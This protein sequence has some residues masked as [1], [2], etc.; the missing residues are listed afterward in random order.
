MTWTAGKSNL[1]RLGG[2]QTL[3]HA[4]VLNAVHPDDR[5]GVRS[6][7]YGAV[8]RSEPYFREFRVVLPSGAIR[9]ILSRGTVFHDAEGRPIRMLGVNV[10]ITDRKL[11][12]EALADSEERFRETFE[13]AEVGIAHVLPSARFSLTNAKMRALFGY[14]SD[15]MAALTVTDIIYP[16]D[17]DGAVVDRD[18]LFSGKVKSYTRQRR[19]VRKDRSVFPAEVMA[20]GVRNA[21]GAIKYI[22]LI[23]T[24]VSEAKL[25]AEEMERALRLADAANAA[26]S[27]F[28]ANVSHEIRTPLTA[29]MGFAELLNAPNVD[30]RRQRQ[31]AE[32]IERNGTVLRAL[33]DDILDLSR[34]EAGR[35]GIEIARLS[36]FDLLAEVEA[37]FQPLATARKLALA[38]VRVD[39]VPDRIYGDALRLR[40][41]LINLVGNALKFTEEGGVTLTVEQR[42]P[43]NGLVELAFV[44]TDTG[45]GIAEA[46]KG[47]LFQAFSQADPSTTRKYGGTGLGLVLTR[48]LTRMFHGDLVLRDSAVGVGSTF[49]ATVSVAITPPES[50]LEPAAASAGAESPK[51]ALQGLHVLVAEDCTDTAAF[52]TVVLE[53]AGATVEHAEDGRQ[54]VERALGREFAVILMDLQMPRLDGREATRELRRQGYARPIIALSAHAFPKD[55]EECLAIGFDSFVSKPVRAQSL[56]EAVEQTLKRSLGSMPQAAD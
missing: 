33:I 34:I 44:V 48:H 21:A 38:V 22:I 16:A 20:T 56:L 36:L 15:E 35:V 6:A 12:E 2:Q 5:E 42:P 8:E 46:H 40:Q 7:A 31:Y 26:K 24:D 17:F 55:R 47:R 43:R 29:I 13:R 45:V 37:H 52:V 32:V 23:I 27:Q 51:K 18:Q 19:F 10:D 49:V 54:A 9:W 39:D 50:G 41:I 53:A 4:E 25:V 28:L 11:A 3:S 14:S 30:Q 1:V